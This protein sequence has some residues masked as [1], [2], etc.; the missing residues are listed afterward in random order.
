MFYTRDFSQNNNLS[1]TEKKKTKIVKD[2]LFYNFVIIHNII[3]IIYIR[4]FIASSIKST[5]RI[6]VYERDTVYILFRTKFILTEKLIIVFFIISDCLSCINILGLRKKKKK[7]M[8]KQ[9]IFYVNT[10][11]NVKLKR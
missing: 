2:L 4:I 3:H 6:F 1:L 9:K 7:M 11:T 8:I 10:Y 5:V